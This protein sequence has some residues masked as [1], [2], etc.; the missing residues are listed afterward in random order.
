MKHIHTLS[1]IMRFCLIS[2]ISILTSAFAQD[3]HLSQYDA[4]SHY[5]NPALT[6]IYFGN[7]ANYRIYSDYRSQ[8][9]SLGIKPFSTYYLAYDM[10]YQLYGFGGY[11]IHNRNGAGGLNTINFMP[12]AAYK[13]SNEVATPH[14][15]SVGVQLGII[16]RSFDPNH[17]TYDS[18]FSTAHP[19]G[20]D[21]SIPSG[22]TFEKTSSLKLDANMGVFYKYKNT[23][24][25]A[26]PWG[27][28]A[29][30]HVTKPSQ[31]LTGIKKD[32][33]GKRIDRMPMR[34]VFQAGADWKITEEIRVTSMLLYM[35]Q[36]Q[37]QELNIGAIGFYHIKETNYDVLGG[38]NYRW[39][40]A[41]IV[42]AGM[43]YEQ[44][45]ITLSYDINTSYL[46]NYTNGRGAFEFSILLTGIKGKPLFNPKFKKG[47]S[48]LKTL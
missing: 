39:K 35:N 29:V 48:I 45:I 22:E 10:P 47:S 25:K 2:H 17:F 20:F 19:N 43:K 21:P 5:F 37:A 9:K 24:W 46:N 23:Q 36:A 38:L 26:N 6:G 44:H 13:I 32:T 27:G 30:Y 18:Q 31:S 12:S 40:D 33:A 3:F 42:Q 14:N 16:Y 11:L 4:T 41:V 34:F 8:W 1:A 28:F 7:S 15:L